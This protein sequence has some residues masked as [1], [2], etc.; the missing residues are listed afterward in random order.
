[1]EKK[2]FVVFIRLEDGTAKKKRVKA[3]TIDEAIDKIMNKGFVYARWE[4][5]QYYEALRRQ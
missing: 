4:T 1:M 3:Y 2:F 5:I